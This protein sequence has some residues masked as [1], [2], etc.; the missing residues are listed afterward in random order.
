M[1]AGRIYQTSFQEAVAGLFVPSMGTEVV[2]PLL[3]TL[4]QLLRPRHVLEIGMGYTTPFLAAALADVRQQVARDSAAL[5]AK[6]AAHLGS[7][8]RLDGD[9][10]DAAPALATPAAYLTAYEPRLIAVDNLSNE[11]SSAGR[12]RDALKDLNLTGQVDI[13][14]ADVRGLRDALPDDFTPVD[15]AWVDAWE[16]LY[17]FDHFW[18]LM[19]PDGG[20]IAMHYLLT[21]PEGEAIVKYI[22]RFARKH[23][24]AIE[25][26]NLLEPH[27]LAQNSITLLRRI[28]GVPARAYAGAGAEISYGEALHRDATQQAGLRPDTVR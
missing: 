25:I 6:T 4:V 12:V 3:S 19:N 18:S 16:C 9:W 24:D 7:G 1:P 20:V 8:R 26:I 21:Y 15:F 22:K 27:K 2:A 28:D 14:N 23:P 17:F 13:V 5:A 11:H 10:L